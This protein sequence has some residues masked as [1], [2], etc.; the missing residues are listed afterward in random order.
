MSITLKCA[1]DFREVFII[2]SERLLIQPKSVVCTFKLEMFTQHSLTSQS[3][4]LEKP[5]ASE[6][7]LFYIVEKGNSPYHC[8]VV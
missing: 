3:S 4:G 5:G 2:K 1:T 7:E 6:M 8:S